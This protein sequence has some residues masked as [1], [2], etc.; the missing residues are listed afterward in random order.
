MKT[1]FRLQMLLT[2]AVLVGVV[3]SSHGSTAKLNSAVLDKMVGVWD[4]KVSVHEPKSVQMTGVEEFKWV[5]GGTYL[6][7]KSLERS[8]DAEDIFMVSYDEQLGLFRNWVFSKG[9]QC[10]ELQGKWNEEKQTM[11]WASSRDA[12]LLF[13]ATWVFHD[14]KTRAWDLSVTNK[15]GVVLYRL[16]GEATLRDPEP[17]APVPD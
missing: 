17:E 5:L 3:R 12:D 7:G 2:V 13:D 4:I 1:V 10:K 8:D 6:Q 9:A 15:D 14:E 11:V 16:S